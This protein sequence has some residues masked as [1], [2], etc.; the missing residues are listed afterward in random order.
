LDLS[1]KSVTE[2]LDDLLVAPDDVITLVT[3]HT[4][5]PKLG[6][7]IRMDE[8]QKA[9]TTLLVDLESVLRDVGLFDGFARNLSGA[10]RLEVL[11]EVCK[12]EYSIGVRVAVR[13]W[14]TYCA[15]VVTHGGDQIPKFV[16]DC[17]LRKVLPVEKVKDFTPGLFLNV[18]EREI[19]SLGVPEQ[20]FMQVVNELA[21]ALGNLA[22]EEAAERE[23][24]AADSI[25]CIV[26]RRVNTVVVELVP[27]GQARQTTPHDRHSHGRTRRRSRQGVAQRPR[28]RANPADHG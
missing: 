19:E 22:R 5:R 4:K 8:E 16:D 23:A 12:V 7:P 2:T 18:L 21:P 20:G 26:Q 14:L 11:T 13:R 28:D 25:A 10:T 1:V 24:A 3:E 9:Q 6:S 17:R 27:T 15:Q